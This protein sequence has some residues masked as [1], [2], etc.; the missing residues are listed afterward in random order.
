M[1]YIGID[2]E[3]AIEHFKKLGCSLTL[4]ERPDTITRLAWENDDFFIPVYT[5]WYKVSGG[6]L[7]KMGGRKFHQYLKD[8]GL[9]KSQQ[10]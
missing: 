1:N 4:I 5:T 9:L 8:H 6:S 10:D 2:N 7:P 3:K